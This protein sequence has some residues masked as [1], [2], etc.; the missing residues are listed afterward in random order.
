MRRRLRL[1]SRAPAPPSPSS[2]ST[3]AEASIEPAGTPVKKAGQ[4]IWSVP[5]S[6]RTRG[7]LR[8]TSAG[9]RANPH[10]G[11]LH[12]LSRLG[13]E[14]AAVRPL[15]L[16]SEPTRWL[17]RV[18]RSLQD[19]P[20]SEDQERPC[21]GYAPAGCHHG[22]GAGVL[23]LSART[24]TRDPRWVILRA[25]GVEAIWWPPGARL[26]ERALLWVGCLLALPHVRLVVS[27]EPSGLVNSL[28]WSMS[29]R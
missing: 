15:R 28:A 12:G 22:A 1:P 3:P 13:R 8:R 26:D 24:L 16:V 5:P 27:V 11:E 21:L 4:T 9:C 7:L 14:N 19:V 29:S 17:A 18:A 25:C 20:T 10:Q 2:E 23:G 6:L